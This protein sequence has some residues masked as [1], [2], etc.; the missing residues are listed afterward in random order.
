M[1]N[2]ELNRIRET[3]GKIVAKLFSLDEGNSTLAPDALTVAAL[4]YIALPT[5]IFL[6]GWLRPWAAI[7]MVVLTLLSLA[8]FIRRDDV[9]WTA[10]YSYG[11]TALIIIVAFTWA[12]LGGAGHFFNANPDW[13][14]R[15][16]VLGDLT[17]TDWPPAY[18]VVDGKPHILR[19]AF[20]FFLPAALVGKLF[21]IASVDLALY[22]YAAIGCSLFLLV[23]P[24]P[25][26]FGTILVVSLLV[27]IFFCGMDYL[28]IVL[29]TGTTPLV[30]LRLSWW[31]PFSYSSLTGSMFWAPNHAIP[32]WL[33]SALFYR[34]WGHRVW[35]A[36][37][38]VMLPLTVIWTPFAAA[39]IAPFLALAT[40]RWFAQGNRFSDSQ[41]TRW[42][43][44]AAIAL[45]WLTLRFITLD[46]ATVSAMKLASSAGPEPDNPG[47]VLQYLLFVL[48]QFVIL[49]LLLRRGL[50][51]SQGL[52]A[53][54]CVVLSLLP[55][56]QFGPSNDIVLRHSVPCVIVLLIA[57]L[58]Q[59]Q[60]WLNARQ[61][62][63][64]GYA[65]AIVI[66]IGAAT[67]FNEIWRAFF[68]K[69]TMPDYGRS[70][71]EQHW[72]TEAPHYV[73]VLDRSDLA[74]VLRAPTLVPNSEQRRAY[75]LVATPPRSR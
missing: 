55:F 37:F 70:L 19:T 3:K 44:I 43:T 45:C 1:A 6:G 39:A 14:I 62:P 48:M 23:L 17:F 4:L 52:F 27:T 18:S 50:Q 2:P 5:L 73:G 65:V 11:A 63:L 32:I 24:M 59:L 67:P 35:P 15:D 30:P 33:V 47:I 28:G 16:K 60:D 10:P 72:N 20:G 36:L 64:R 29:I 7:P 9:R 21:G 42:Q 8:Q 46:F 66:L 69:R 61:V 74:S 34:H 38:M 31:V 26:K 53:L 13:L 40:W 54:A 75:G 25:K 56:V 41:I 57:T 12:S 49:A 68:F 58:A 22:A 71:L 51:H